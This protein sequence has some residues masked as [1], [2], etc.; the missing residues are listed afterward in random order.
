MLAPSLN[1]AP[2]FFVAVARSEP[3]RSISDILATR[4]SADKLA[5]LS[6]CLVK[7]YT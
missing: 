4:T 2:L 1:L 7:T 6:R 3:A 5:V